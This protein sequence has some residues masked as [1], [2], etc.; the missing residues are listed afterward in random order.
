MYIDIIE[1]ISEHNK[2][3]SPLRYKKLDKIFYTVQN[4]T[5]C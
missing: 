3:L 1:M 5:F 4:E 2:G